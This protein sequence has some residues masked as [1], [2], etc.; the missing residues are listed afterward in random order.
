MIRFL[1]IND[2]TSISSCQRNTSKNKH[3]LPFLELLTRLHFPTQLSTQWWVREIEYLA[4]LAMY[5]LFVAS[6]AIHCMLLPGILIDIATLASTFDSNYN[7]P[8][9][10]QTNQGT[11]LCCINS[12][13]PLLPAKS[14]DLAESRN[15]QALL[16]RNQDAL[17]F[18]ESAFP[19]GPIHPSGPINS[20]SFNCYYR[21]SS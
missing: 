15:Q 18:P 6:D 12:F 13:W 7:V 9:C 17:L 20:K 19:A 8:R 21:P 4:V 2:F 1:A 5:K 16:N 14:T 11:V 10:S 3:A